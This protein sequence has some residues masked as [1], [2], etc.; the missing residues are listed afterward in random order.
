MRR[1]YGGGGGGGGGMVGMVW[2]LPHQH[3]LQRCKRGCCSFRPRTHNIHPHIKYRERL[4]HWHLRS[5]RHFRSHKFVRGNNLAPKANLVWWYHHI[6]PTVRTLSSS[7]S[8]YTA[9][10]SSESEERKKRQENS[11]SY[12]DN[13]L[14][15][16]KS[17]TQQHLG[18]VPHTIP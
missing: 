11:L 14:C 4:S 18:I 16:A 9:F 2:Y 7:Y 12:I 3:Q 10:N 6:F 8:D 5:Q 15:R 1:W 13:A 17:Q